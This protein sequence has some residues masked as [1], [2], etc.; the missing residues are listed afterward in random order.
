[1]VELEGEPRNGGRDRV[2]VVLATGVAVAIN[3]IIVGV[4]WGTLADTET[5]LSEN[6]THILTIALVGCIGLLAGY[7][8]FKFGAISR[9]RNDD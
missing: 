9:S 8:G 4:V 5:G 1:V 3:L 2:A 6:S 7:L